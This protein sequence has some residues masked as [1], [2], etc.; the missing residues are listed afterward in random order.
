M[1]SVAVRDSP[2]S[3]AGI[4]RWVPILIFGTGLALTLALLGY[5][6][7]AWKTRQIDLATQQLRGM[8]DGLGPLAWLLTSDGIVLNANRTATQTLQHPESEMLDRPLWE[9]PLNVEARDR[10][11]ICQAVHAARGA[12]EARF[13]FTVEIAGETRVLDLWVRQLGDEANLVASAVDVTDRH[14]A[15]E[16]QRLLMR[17]LDHRMKNTL[18]VI[19]AVIRRTAKSHHSVATFEQSLL[20]RVRA[21]SRAHELLAGERWLGADIDTIVRQ[22]T[23]TFDA[24]GVI[25]ID[26]PRIRLNPKAALSFA[27]AIH[28]LGTNAS[29]YGG[30][31]S[32]KGTVDINW[33]IE[34]VD[35]KPWLALSWQESGGPPVEMP[36]ERGFGSMLIE[37]SIAYELGGD[38]R[39]EFRATGLSVVIKAPLQSIRPFV[40]ER[41]SEATMG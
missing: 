13:D 8:L 30:L 41:V 9:M 31:S 25:R 34:R 5:V 18:Q 16:T 6:A 19:Q 10:D 37:R 1:W 22:E 40:S 3:T 24:G 27:L 23:S 35:G 32:A 11:R 7:S 15:E 12:A 29:K 4:F 36:T 20:G 28:E 38:A 26:G 2:V 39:M 21:M 17:E 14:E 33:A